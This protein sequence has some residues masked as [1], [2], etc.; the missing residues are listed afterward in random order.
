MN[1]RSDR[2]KFC[3]RLCKNIGIQKNHSHLCSECGVSFITKKKSSKFCSMSCSGKSANR[4]I[5]NHRNGVKTG[6]D[7]WNWKRG[8]NFNGLGYV[9]INVGVRKG[10]YQHRKVMEDYLG[11]KLDSTEHV[12]HINGDKGD[13]R[14]EN[15][16]ILSNSEHLKLHW[17]LRR[18]N[19]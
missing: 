17:R 18:G 13:N 16:M 19:A 11:R 2:S 3:S 12:H 10:A 1:Y 9:Q 8:W 5:K 6:E 7:H 15:L 14:I 4:Q